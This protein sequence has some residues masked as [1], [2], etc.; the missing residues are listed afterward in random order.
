VRLLDANV[1]I[2]AKN[3]HYAFDVFTAFWD[4]LD[5]CAET[6]EIASTDMVYDEHADQGDELAAWV[7]DRKE[8]LFHVESTSQAVAEQVAEIGRWMNSVPFRAHVQAEFMDGADPFLA[9]TA[10]VRGDTIVTLETFDAA[11]RKKVKLP[12]A[13]QHLGV[14]YETT[15]QMLSRLNARFT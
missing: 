11:C 1:F 3:F 13:C 15:Y 7:R 14:S 12:N 2:T 4:W 6:G 10:Q 9:G 5:T 8:S